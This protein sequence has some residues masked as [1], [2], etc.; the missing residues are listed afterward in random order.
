MYRDWVRPNT[1][2]RPLVMIVPRPNLAI[3]AA[4]AGLLESSAVIV[5]WWA[6]DYRKWQETSSLIRAAAP[7]P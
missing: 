6:H 4:I 7:I 2:V 5:A 3:L 1:R